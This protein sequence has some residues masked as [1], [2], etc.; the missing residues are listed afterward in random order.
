[1][2][3]YITT[4]QTNKWQIKVSCHD[5]CFWHHDYW[6]ILDWVD[7]ETAP[8]FRSIE[9][10]LNHYWY[11]KIDNDWAE[12]GLYLWEEIDIDCYQITWSW[13]VQKN[14]YKSDMFLSFKTQEQAEL[15][16][17]KLL[18]IK[19][20]WKW[21]TLNDWEFKPDW[22]DENQ[23]KWSVYYKLNTLKLWIYD[24]YTLKSNDYPVFSSEEIAEKAIKECEQDYLLLLTK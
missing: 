9:A 23:A 8:V 19:N 16:R 13:R 4:I 24:I 11:K 22:K 3:N 14:Q 20:I 12:N 6:Y 2:S 1:M 7:F 18:A 15:F 21:K 17:D 5:D 10:L